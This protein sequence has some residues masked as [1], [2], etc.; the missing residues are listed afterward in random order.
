MT[1]LQV[2]EAA[3]NIREAIAKGDLIKADIIAAGIVASFEQANEHHF[4]AWSDKEAMAELAFQGI[5]TETE[6]AR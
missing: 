4:Q 2:I 1:E 6:V 3:H 5:E